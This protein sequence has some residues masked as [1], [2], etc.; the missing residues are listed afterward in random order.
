MPV[1]GRNSQDQYNQRGACHA[2]QTLGRLSWEGKAISLAV[3]GICRSVC[4]AE[5][6]GAECRGF[7]VCR[8]ALL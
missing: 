4:L 1:W 5:G 7:R 3:C 8:L 2:N 6:L